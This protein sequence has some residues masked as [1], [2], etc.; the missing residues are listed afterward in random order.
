MGQKA[1][2]NE[3]LQKLVDEADEDGSGEIEYS[4][5]LTIM[6]NVKS[7]KNSAIGDKLSGG[8]KFGF[9]KAVKSPFKSKQP[10]NERQL[11][12]D[13]EAERGSWILAV[14]GVIATI[15]ANKSAALKEASAQDT[16]PPAD[17]AASTTK[18]PPAMKTSEKTPKGVGAE[19][20]RH[21]GENGF[22]NELSANLSS[23]L[24]AEDPMKTPAS[25]TKASAGPGALPPRPVSMSLGSSPTLGSGAVGPSSPKRASP[26]QPAILMGSTPEVR[27]GEERIGDALR[28]PVDSIRS[29]FALGSL[30][31][32]PFKRHN[33]SQLG[34]T[35]TTSSVQGSAATPNTAVSKP[36]R[37]KF[38]GAASPAPMAPSLLG[39]AATPN[40]IHK[41]RGVSH[42]TKVS[43]SSF[44]VR[45]VK[46][47]EEKGSGSK[48]SKTAV[49][50]P[51]APTSKASP[52]PSHAGGP[53]KKAGVGSLRTGFGRKAATP[54]RRNVVPTSSVS[55]KVPALHPVQEEHKRQELSTPA[56]EVQEEDKVDA[57]A[58]D[59]VLQ[60]PSPPNTTTQAADPPWATLTEVEA[61]LKREKD[62]LE[63]QLVL[64][65]RM[66]EEL[67][68]T[69][70]AATREHDERERVMKLHLE[71][72][73]E[74]V[75]ALKGGA[76]GGNK[77][78]YER[79][80]RLEAQVE[81][82]QNLVSTTNAEAENVR[83]R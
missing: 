60:P 41:D 56:H 46:A 55:T 19:A 25:S 57:S 14:E 67:N 34:N 65:I 28:I 4:E 63:Q 43:G 68:G 52:T 78:L 6:F 13:N 74:E 58:N 23:D 50:P 83:N 71:T 7:G 10:S 45:P 72:L 77:A 49:Q 42:L 3:E 33:S 36:A 26:K 76:V 32:T 81:G 44:G 66:N 9:S 62:S 47:A 39:N 40:R 53:V 51:P 61:R 30:S 48:F 24:E 59:L 54:E 21:R 37:S 73:A 22:V 12:A 80:N 27:G 8:L 70:E 79:N 2:S 31:L 15:K 64:V 29:R 38:I 82:L 35:S 11:W 18:P 69:L 1:A 16:K 20:E 5:F 17:K 75:G